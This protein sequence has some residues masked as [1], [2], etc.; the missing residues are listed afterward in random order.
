MANK[1]RGAPVAVANKAPHAPA[2]A[3]AAAAAACSLP[4][5]VD[6]GE[7]V[8]QQARALAHQDQRAAPSILL[9]PEPVVERAVD[10]DLIHLTRS[11]EL[12]VYEA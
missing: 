6:R 5:G 1:A 10:T 11:L 9:P 3:A 2:A 7:R 12:L 8:H 4:S